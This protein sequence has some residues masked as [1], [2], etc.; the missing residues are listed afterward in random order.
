[1]RNEIW[2]TEDEICSRGTIYQASSDDGLRPSKRNLGGAI[3]LAA[4]EDYLSMDEQVHKDAERFL[5]PRTPERQKHYEWAVALDHGI[6]PA[7]LRDALDRFKAKWDWQRF[8]RNALRNQRAYTA[9]YGKGDG[10]EDK[11]C[12]KWIR[13][14]R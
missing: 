2:I 5:Y 10:N 6:N 14:D 9:A 1:V 12:S 8:E 13:P 7:W 3:V 4:I 11:R